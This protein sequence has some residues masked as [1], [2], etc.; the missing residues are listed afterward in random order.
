MATTH[1]AVSVPLAKMRDSSVAEAEA[2]RSEVA[3]PA[4]VLSRPGGGAQEPT[5]SCSCS[6]R[7]P[8]QLAVA[9]APLVLPQRRGAHAEPVAL[10]PLGAVALDLPAVEDA[11]ALL[12]I[13]ALALLGQSAAPGI[14]RPRGTGI[15][16]AATPRDAQPGGCSA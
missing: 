15:D 8:L 2:L 4:R 10:G 9:S 5:N 12:A 13:V 3:A 11:L 14:A 6:S 16:G 7:A 1:E